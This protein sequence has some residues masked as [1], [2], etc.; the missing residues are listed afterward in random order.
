MRAG[1]HRFVCA[2]IAAALLC[3]VVRAG[4]LEP[5]DIRHVTVDGEIGRR[6]EVT[7]ANNLLV[8]DL[9]K[10][11]LLPFTERNRTGGY[12]GL[13]KLVDSMVRLAAHTGNEQLLE[14]K[15]RAVEQ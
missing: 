2:V 11:F 4:T 1:N 12:V 15:K 14:R 10:D 5:V 7:V 9:E 3:A 6:V 8:L 13:G